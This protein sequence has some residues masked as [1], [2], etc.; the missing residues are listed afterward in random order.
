MQ[1]SNERESTKNVLKVQA[2]KYKEIIIIY[3]SIKRTVK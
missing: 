3:K 1:R 2:E